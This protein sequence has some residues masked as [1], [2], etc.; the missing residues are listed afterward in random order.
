MVDILRE[1]LLSFGA[2][3]FVFQFGIKKTKIKMH[4]N[5][6]LPTVLYGCEIQS[7][8]LREE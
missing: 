2:E 4:R 3:S 1:R 8:I 7:L 6:N 5:R